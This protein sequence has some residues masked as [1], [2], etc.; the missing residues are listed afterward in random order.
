MSDQNNQWQE[1]GG[2]TV[3]PKIVQQQ[4]KALL[5]LRN[6]LQGVVEREKKNVAVARE[7]LHRMKHGG[8]S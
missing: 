7:Q 8:G 2:K 5:R 4:M 3:Q 6:L 1:V